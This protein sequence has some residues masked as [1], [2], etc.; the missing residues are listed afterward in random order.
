V[1]FSC[2]VDG[3]AT[4]SFSVGEVTVPLEQD[5]SR[6]FAQLRIE[7]PALWWPHT[8]GT[9]A[10]HDCA[11]TITVDGISQTLVLGRIGFRMI[12]VL[13][14]DGDFE[15]RV[16]GVP[17]FCRGVCW[18]PDDLAALE[19]LR[20]AG[21]NMVRVGGTMVYEDDAFY[22]RCDE[23]GV[24]VWQDF[25]FAN[26]DYPAEDEGFM[27][28]VREE[29]TGQLQRLRRHPAVAIYCGNSEV[30]QQAAMLG[31]PRELWRNRL[32]G[33]MLPELCAREHPGTVYVP[34]SP[35]GGAMPFHAGTGVTHYYGVGA[36]LRP[37]ADA[38]RA[39]VRFA[40]ECLGFANIPA[41]EVVDEVMEG[42]AFAAHDPRWKRRTPRDTGSPW[43]FEDV[44]D[45]Y[46]RDL[47]SVDP[48]Q[49]RSFDPQ[50]YLALSRVVTGEVMAQVF[51]EWRST[52]SHCR[53][54]LVWF[55]RD[56]W[57][58]AGW[59]I[60]DSRG[61]PKACFY[62]LRRVWQPR[63]VV[64]ADEGLD[65]I[66]AHVLNDSDQPLEG[67]LELTLL[68]DGHVVI[69]QAST[70]VQVTARGRGLF[71]AE[72]VL[73]TF[74]DTAYAYRFGPAK[75]EVFIATLSVDGDVIG[76][77][78]HF[79]L[80]TEPARI[81]GATIVAEARDEVVT[82]R[83]DRFLYAVHID[84]PGFV[85]HDDYFHL[86]PRRTKTVSLKGSGR[87]GGSLTALNLDG[88]VRIV[89]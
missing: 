82:V 16:N 78:F 80:R 46:L 27:A 28:S 57:P 11:A 47:F 12:E 56:L 75:H 6:V 72:E 65:G 32:F 60:L 4:G 88:E 64:L 50:R 85:A 30:E 2:L 19:L 48:V 37:I 23:L 68:R 15:V 66:H 22:D 18:T 62:F 14:D 26:M 8:H 13:Q 36:Y 31:M 25:M 59:G 84:V 44:R 61:M 55:L 17:V 67:T 29:V 77:A 53:G 5:G 89:V 38:R 3:G 40:S 9:P 83:S 42:D 10:L 63:T 70:P 71:V 33:E 45:H 69:A 79:P 76:E 21:A 81:T 51:S 73:G 43:D 7:N 74:Y 86:A 1:E 54:A 41:Q 20:D 24:L 58:G 52:R 87:F 49:L 39:N 35:S 34:S